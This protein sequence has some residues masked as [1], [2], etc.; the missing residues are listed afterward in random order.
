MDLYNDFNNQSTEFL[1]AVETVLPNEPNL[2][3]YK[4]AFTQLKVFS[5][6]QPVSLFMDSLG[7]FGANIMSKDINFFGSNKDP[8]HIG[9]KLGINNYWDSFSYETKEAI[10]SYL[11]ILYILGMKIL[12]RTE[13]LQAILNNAA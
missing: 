13:E 5:P 6:R 10:W 1:R 7:P 3:D 8:H 4:F 11:Q 2:K 12:N 9:N